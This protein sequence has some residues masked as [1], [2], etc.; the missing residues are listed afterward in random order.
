MTR[1][2]EHRCST[3]LAFALE[4]L[5]DRLVVGQDGDV[6]LG[7]IGQFTLQGSLATSEPLQR[8]KEAM[9][10][11]AKEH[12]RRLDQEIGAE[13]RAI[14]IYDKRRLFHSTGLELEMVHTL[15]ILVS[16]QPLFGQGSHEI[17][18]P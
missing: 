15:T 2:G 18:W 12:K 14:K 13:Q 9:G 16:A 17:R 4:K 1:G 5:E 8:R 6:D 10:L 7:C 3:P 11:L